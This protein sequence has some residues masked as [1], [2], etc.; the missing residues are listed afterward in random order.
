MRKKNKKIAIIILT[1]LAIIIA[2]VLNHQNTWFEFTSTKAEIPM[3]A[4]IQANSTT[5]GSI[6]HGSAIDEEG[7]TVVV[8]NH[9]NGT[10]QDT[11]FRLFDES[12]TPIGAETIATSNTS[13]DQLNPSVAMDEKGNF[14]IAFTG[15]NSGSSTLD[16]YARAFQPNGTPIG[17]DVIVNT[18][19]ANDDNGAKVALDYNGPSD[20]S[21]FVVSWTHNNGS[22]LDTY[23]RLF[24]VDFTQT[25]TAPVSYS[26]ETIF[27]TGY[28]GNQ[29][30]SNVA[31]NNLK[32]FIVTA[33]HSPGTGSTALYRIFAQDGTP[34]TALTE[35][36]VSGTYVSDPDVATDK[37]AR[38]TLN[39]TE[40]IRFIL[41]YTKNQPLQ[42]TYNIVSK[43]IDCTDPNTANNND[44]DITCSLSAPE[45]LDTRANTNSKSAPAVDADYLGNF[46]VT[47]TDSGIDGNNSGIAGQSYNYKGQ[48]VSQPFQVNGT[49]TTG[50][51]ESP[52]ISMN[53]DGFYDISF[54]D[55]NGT[56]THFKKYVNEIFKAENETLAHPAD[57]LNTQSTVATA[58]SPTHN[59][60]MVWMDYGTSPASLKYTLQ[61]INQSDPANPSINILKDAQVIATGN[62]I[63]NPAVDFFKDD[64]NCNRF[65]VVWENDLGAGNGKDIFY[66]IFDSAGN[67]EYGTP[68]TITATT[69]AESKPTVSA[70]I[71]NN[72]STDVKIF[73][74]GWLNVTNTS[75]ESTYHNNGTFQPATVSANC[76][77][78]IMCT[79]VKNSLNPNNNRVVFSYDALISDGNSNIY[80]QQ[81]DSY[82]LVGNPVEINSATAQNNGSDIAFITDD[83]FAVVY[84]YYN[85]G[86]GI[87]NIQGS[88]YTY[89]ATSGGDGNQDPDLVEDFDIS[90]NYLSSS[91][92][93]TNIKISGYPT[94]TASLQQFLVVW[95]LTYPSTD[96]HVMG[97]F[98]DYSGSAITPFGPSFRIN[99]SRISDS[100]LPDVGYNRYG[101]GIVAWEG[102]SATD[103]WGIQYQLIQ[104]PSI[105]EEMGPLEPVCR[106]EITAG[107]LT[108]NAPTT[109]SFP[110]VSVS[111]TETEIQEVS[112]RDTTYGG[113]VKYIEVQDATGEDFTLSIMVSDFVSEADDKTYIKADEHFKVK[114]WDD[115]TTLTNPNCDSE[116]PSNCFLTENSTYSPTAF[117]LSSETQNYAFANTQKVLATKTITQQSEIGRWKIYPKFWISVPPIIPAGLHEATITFTLVN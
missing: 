10:D 26:S 100:Y 44:T 96:I 2:A 90:Q 14:V 82:T 113:D 111:A 73:S 21:R 51:Q 18:T 110:A 74:A 102:E 8:W 57:D 35:I 83:D 114:N 109:I 60:V 16:I 103:S 79:N 4:E 75:V 1:V 99:T 23:Y 55:F 25:S 80:I 47:W 95:N 48:I 58:I 81:L 11:Y 38:S 106:Q 85:S 89:D 91:N 61:Q 66:N 31:M 77:G 59:Q 108:I 42:S 6:S 72:G 117:S 88:R 115:S 20:A 3:T 9:H 93:D 70:G 34:L 12:G 53:T 94:S 27:H 52:R 87:N 30:K 86:L 68:Q 54:F 41:S 36:P 63:N 28:S 84:N 104:N 67:A 29:Y 45:L 32:Q 62:N 112:V 105:M 92:S 116:N 50:V 22:D 107:G 71:Y 69:D 64:T 5:N 17:N 24:N 7:N 49:I 98:L 76:G 101:L 65:I 56:D 43:I 40:D 13:G 37:K 33:E 39:D 15:Y 78:G 19:T 46:T 97:Q